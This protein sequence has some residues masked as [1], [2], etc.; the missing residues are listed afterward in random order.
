VFV[1]PKSSGA[2]LSNQVTVTQTL[3]KSYESILTAPAL[4][5]SEG[6]RQRWEFTLLSAES[7]A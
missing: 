6:S 5:P 4:S 3:S 7:S 1:E 2:E